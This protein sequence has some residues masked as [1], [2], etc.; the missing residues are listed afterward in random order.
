MPRVLQIAIQHA[1]SLRG[2]SVVVLPGD[3]A[4]LAAENEDLEHPPAVSRP[5][6]VP[7][8]EEIDRLAELVD[9]A[10]SVTLF[11]GAGS[12]AAH[13]DVVALAKRLKAPV[14]YA[15]RGKQHI[16][17]DNPY[18]VGMT[19]LLGYGGAY[20]A[21]HNADLLLLLGTDFPYEQFMPTNGTIVQI[22]VRGER[23][24]RRSRLDLGIWG[25][26]GETLRALLPKV[27]EKSDDTHLR[28]AQR[29]HR[30]VAD[31]LLAYVEHPGG[32]GAIRPEYLT[33]VVDELAP[34]D[35]IFTMDTGTPNI[36]GA[37]YL[38]ATAERRLLASYMHGSMACALPQ[39]IGAQLLYPERQVIAL[40]GDG[41]LSMLLGDLL[42]VMQY[43]LPVKIVVFNNRELGFVKIEMLQAGFPDW[44]TDLWDPNFA[45]I[46]EAIGAVGIRIE[47]TAAVRDGLERALAHEGP[48]V[49]DV[50]VEP[51]A[52]AL[53]P[54]ITIGQAE[55]F[56][57]A[58]A[59]EALSHRFGDVADIA[60]AN[61]H[62]LR[63]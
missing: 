54:H 49:V 46:A 55:G 45:K 1:I 35:A 38:R 31:R 63:P 43:R 18:A 56:A 14:A 61:L 20:A 62:L 48:V 44:Q 4:G 27:A 2:V 12:A 39:A 5:R 26:V 24:G 60:V 37:R 29:E 7:A 40:A 16:E 13:D 9:G 36:W 6:I 33:A 23:L 58:L 28:A 21:M 15:F 30:E 41:G 22:D 34:D 50:L 17:P 51:N 19:G 3:V 8:D 57:L 11:C 10:R 59:K 32:T 25:D 53:P 42:T 52:L 47:E